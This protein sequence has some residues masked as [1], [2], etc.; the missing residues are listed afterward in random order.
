MYLT[1][2]RA[3]LITFRFTCTR[4]SGAGALLQSKLDQKCIRVFRSSNLS[5][6]RWKPPPT[7]GSTVYRYDGLYMVADC[8]GLSDQSETFAHDKY[9]SQRR[10]LILH[11]SSNTMWYPINIFQCSIHEIYREDP[12]CF[13]SKRAPS[14]SQDSGE[15][16]KHN[17]WLPAG[18]L[19]QERPKQVDY[20]KDDGNI[21][22]LG[23][24]SCSRDL[25]NRLPKI[26]TNAMTIKG[27]KVSIIQPICVLSDL[28]LRCTSSPV[29]IYYM[30]HA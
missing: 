29:V 22:Q 14:S 4:K 26:I 12:P 3:D 18:H 10:Y 27:F 13:K 9:D 7:V 15:K 8:M 19:Q 1:L 24:A 6:S 16:R 30:V 28:N 20:L 21:Q 25:K 11:F 17:G 5:N 2:N 23:N